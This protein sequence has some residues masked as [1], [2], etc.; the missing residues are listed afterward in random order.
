M[1]YW[2]GIPMKDTPLMRRSSTLSLLS[3]LTQR[4]P[5]KSDVLNTWLNS[6][7]R[8]STKSASKVLAKKDKKDKKKMKKKKKKN[9][10]A[11]DLN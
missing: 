4:G 11:D 2:P 3:L 8:T 5:R 6:K 7:S 10:K 9:R 1:G